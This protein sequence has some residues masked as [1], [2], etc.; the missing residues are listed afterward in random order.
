MSLYRAFP[1]PLRQAQIVVTFFCLII[2]FLC[3]LF[4][5]K[6]KSLLRSIASFLIMAL[7]YVCLQTMAGDAKRNSEPFLFSGFP[8]WVTD[9]PAIAVNAAFILM[10][11]GTVLLLIDTTHTYLCEP[12]PR[13]FSKL[14]VSIHDT[15]GLSL[16]A[17]KAYC[18]GQDIDRDTVRLLYAKCSDC[19]G[20]EKLFQEGS[21]ESIRQIG[22]LIG[23]GL[24]VSGVLPDDD[25]YTP[26]ICNVLSEC[27]INTFRH[28]WG[29]MVYADCSFDGETKIVI[30]NNGRRP[31]EE[32]NLRGGL[33]HLH[34]YAETLG[35]KITIES[36]PE[37][38]LTLTI[39]KENSNGF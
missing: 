10:L 22:K 39:P 35:A 11:V 30:H 38:K 2:V 16:V 33:K 17:I 23:V 12:K 3:L 1:L 18:N 31:S 25:K 15:F 5:L 26:L 8:I 24:N 13:K 34:D 29:D 27:M 37:F 20:K 21:Y 32:I 6:R 36:L 19:F 7:S 4:F 14:K 28:A 9:L